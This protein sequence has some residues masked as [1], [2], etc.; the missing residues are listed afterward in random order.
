MLLLS[1]QPPN[2]SLHR[3]RTPSRLGEFRLKS[4]WKGVDNSGGIVFPTQCAGYWDLGCGCVKIH[5]SIH[6][7]LICWKCRNLS[8]SKSLMNWNQKS[9]SNISTS[10]LRWSYSCLKG[11]LVGKGTYEIT[12]LS[13]VVTSWFI[14]SQTWTGYIGTSITIVSKS[15]YDPPFHTKKS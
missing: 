12:E 10:N 13:S 4:F 8:P 9:I 6:H 5:A 2:R 7:N 11:R 1:M 14:Q 15:I 3:I